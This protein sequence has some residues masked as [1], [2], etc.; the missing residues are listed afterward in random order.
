MMCEIQSPKDLQ[1]ADICAHYRPFFLYRYCISQ[2]PLILVIRIP[3]NTNEF[4]AICIA[5]CAVKILAVFFDGLFASSGFLDYQLATTFLPIRTRYRR[6]P[7]R[8]NGRVQNLR[9]VQSCGHIRKVER[10]RR[11]HKRPP[12]SFPVS[13]LSYAQV[14]LKVL[15]IARNTYYKYKRELRNAI[16]I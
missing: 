15:A 5:E 11:S 16:S 14:V 4:N 1:C 12:P 7:L 3:R 9:M 2:F 6:S 8:G 10:W 13:N